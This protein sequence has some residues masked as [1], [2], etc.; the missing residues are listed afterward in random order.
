M[1]RLPPENSLLSPQASSSL[2]SARDVV[3]GSS[4]PVAS[5]CLAYN[6]T[7]VTIRSPQ[8]G[9]MPQ[10]AGHVEPYHNAGADA[11]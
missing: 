10:S 9:C 6:S 4:S 1:L 2:A 8:Q 7:A 5:C 11:G 3:S